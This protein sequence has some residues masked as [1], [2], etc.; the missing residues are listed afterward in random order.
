MPSTKFSRD[1][2]WNWPNRVVRIFGDVVPAG[3]SLR[4]LLP[5]L[6]PRP[7]NRPFTVTQIKPVTQRR[8]IAWYSAETIM[9]VASLLIASTRGMHV[10]QLRL[11]VRMREPWAG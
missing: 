1:A 11:A 7:L 3:L 2:S 6:L 10:G 8:G 5:D 4:E 9:S